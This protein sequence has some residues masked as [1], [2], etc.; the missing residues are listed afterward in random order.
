MTEFSP[1]IER[2]FADT[3]G[4]CFALSAENNIDSY[5]FAKEFL[6]STWG[7]NLLS[8]NFLREYE[9]PSYMLAKARCNLTLQGGPKYDTYT[10]WMYGY[11]VKYWVTNKNI[12]SKKIWEILPINLFN[13]SFV[14]YHTQ[15]WEYIIIEATKRYKRKE[16]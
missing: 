4:R 8:E 2:W 6:N 12:S 15:G 11:L 16:K 5:L 13:D 10:L 9:S 14:F 1:E 3:V 7:I